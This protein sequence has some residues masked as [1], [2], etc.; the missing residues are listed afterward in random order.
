VIVLLP[1]S[2]IK[3]RAF[4]AQEKLGLI[5]QGDSIGVFVD[6]VTA[7]YEGQIFQIGKI[8]GSSYWWWLPT[9]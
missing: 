4:V 6:G 3:V 9:P 8:P 5:H 7:P 2:N 1:P